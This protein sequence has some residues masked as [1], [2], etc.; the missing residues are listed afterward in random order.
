MR[1]ELL[2]S[3]V[4]YDDYAFSGFLYNFFFKNSLESL[5]NLDEDSFVYWYSQL[6]NFSMSSSS[7]WFFSGAGLFYFLF[8]VAALLSTLFLFLTPNPVNS[9]LH[10]VLVFLNV[11]F[12]ILQY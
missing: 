5:I 6:A 4:F 3:W 12:L 7:V 9:I 10:L 11:A 1:L 2:Q 8:S